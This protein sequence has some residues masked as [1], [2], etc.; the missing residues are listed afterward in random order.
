MSNEPLVLSQILAGLPDEA[1][2]DAV[3]AALMATDR[4]RRFLTEYADRNRH[5]DTTAIVSAIARIEATLRG[6]GP[7]QAD[8]AGDLME[9]AAAIDRIQ[10]AL[11]AGTM[12]APDVSAAIERLSDIAFMLHERPVEA[13]LCDGLDAAVR[14]VSDANMRSQS[15][16]EDVRKAAELLHALASRVGAMMMR[17]IGGRGTDQPAGENVAAESASGAGLFEQATDDGETFA[18]AVAALAASLPT[19]AD[20]P[21]EL[22]EAAPEPESGQG[23]Q[24][25]AIEAAPSDDALLPVDEAQQTATETEV[26]DDSAAPPQFTSTQSSAE[27]SL[28]EAVLSQAFSDDHFSGANFSGEAPAREE[29]GS[30]QVLSEEPPSEDVLQAQ[31]FPTDPDPQEDLADL[32]EP[33]PVPT[34]PIEAAAPVTADNPV[35]AE[36]QAEPARAVPPPPARAIPRPPGS[37]PL[38]AVRDLSEEEL[39]ALFS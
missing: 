2:Y 8:A 7:P 27:V 15:A 1:D 28:S 19:L 4:G 12:P 33:Q 26:A 9:I 38:A 21:S 10:A 14:E 35:P 34:T 29:A 37:D 39:I 32:F 16:A 30:E 17:S 31:N 20:A 25:P 3:Y 23:A 11:A 13:T 6:E 24:A 22:A 18:E 5:A 36:P